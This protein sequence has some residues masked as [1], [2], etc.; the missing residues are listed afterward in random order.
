ML[1]EQQIREV[2]YESIHHFR[3]SSGKVLRRTEGTIAEVISASP[4]SSLED[5]YLWYM[6]KEDGQ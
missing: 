3:Q 4:F 2:L 1:P 6:D 5:T